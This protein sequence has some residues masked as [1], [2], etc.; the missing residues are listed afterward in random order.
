MVIS[1]GWIYPPFPYFCTL[2]NDTGIENIEWICWMKNLSCLRGYSSMIIKIT[3][4]IVFV[5][6]IG[7]CF[8]LRLSNS[9][10]FLHSNEILNLFSCIHPMC[11]QCSVQNTGRLINPSPHQKQGVNTP[12]TPLRH[13]ERNDTGIEN[14]EC[15]CWIEIIPA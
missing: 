10:C 8:P 14:I 6:I 11:Y 1:K 5:V 2:R 3:V 7:S 4:T 15:I 13:G 9:C 12:L